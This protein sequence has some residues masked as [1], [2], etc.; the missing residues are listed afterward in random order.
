MLAVKYNS[1]QV[2]EISI[3]CFNEKLNVIVGFFKCFTI[4]NL[5]CV[6]SLRFY[7]LNE[8]S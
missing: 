7:N 3:K 5:N 1:L 2:C 6:F 8:H 4:S